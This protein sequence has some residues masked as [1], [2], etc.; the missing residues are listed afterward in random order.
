MLPDVDLSGAGPDPRHRSPIRRLIDWL[1][2]LARLVEPTAMPDMTRQDGVRW[3]RREARDHIT[4]VQAGIAAAGD[5]D[6]TGEA[7]HED[8]CERP[9][10]RA[11]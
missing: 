8:A 9:T 10:A 5:S 4:L 6:P 2:A 1:G 7:M 11:A 3:G